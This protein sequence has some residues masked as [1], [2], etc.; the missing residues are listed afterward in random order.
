MNTAT[1]SV[2]LLKNYIGG[3]WVTAET[4]R[5]EVV[6]NPATGEPL[7]RVPI[8]R[9]ADV[10]KAVQAAREAF[11]TWRRTPIPKRARMMFRYHQLL[12][13]HHDELAK[14]VT[15]ENGKSYKEAYGEVLRGIE[16][17]EFAAGVPTHM[18]GET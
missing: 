10:E 18:M 11:D 12:T 16:C 2:S 17:V 4:D 3:K 13:E 14:M 1:K 7:A 9:N 6:P 15:L 8:S 5:E